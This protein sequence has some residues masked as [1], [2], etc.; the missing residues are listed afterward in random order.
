MTTTM[1]ILIM[2]KAMEAREEMTRNHSII[3]MLSKRGEKG[4]KC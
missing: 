2:V 1:E 4:E 3:L